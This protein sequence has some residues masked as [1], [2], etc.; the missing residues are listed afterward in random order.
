MIVNLISSPRTIST[1]LM[2]AF[3]QR[4]DTKVVDEPFYAYYLSETKLP[5]PGFEEIIES[6]PQDPFVVVKDIN[7]LQAAYPVVFQKGMAHHFLQDFNFL[8][9][10]I[11]VFL[12]RHPAPIIASF[13]KVITTPTLRDV[14]IQ[15]QYELFTFL[16]SLGHTPL[17]ID[18]N[19][20]LEN[21][22]KNLQLLC[23][24]IG[25][26]FEPA[27]LSWKPGPLAEDGVWARYW[28]QNVHESSGLAPKAP[29]ETVISPKMQKLVDEAM[30]YF[31]YLSNKRLF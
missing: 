2:Y 18:S 7:Q 22:A 16:E 15:R 26:T 21:P 30:P 17:V 20:L 9:D 10:W 24:S 29:S 6:Q 5:H 1:A 8:K 11:N 23:G 19:N 4:A 28:Y 14:G 13:S 31:E 3:A 12:I 25:L 27:M